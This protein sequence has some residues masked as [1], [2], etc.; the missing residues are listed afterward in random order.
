MTVCSEM[1]SLSWQPYQVIHSLSIDVWIFLSAVF[2][3]WAVQRN[4]R[5]IVSL[6]S[7][8][9][10]FRDLAR[11]KNTDQTKS[12]SRRFWNFSF[13]AMSAVTACWLVYVLWMYVGQAWVFGGACHAV[14]PGCNYLVAVCAV[15][16]ILLYTLKGLIFFVVSHIFNEARCGLF[17][18]R[19]TISYDF[20]F[21]VFAFP[22]LMIFIYSGSWIQAAAFWIVAVLFVIFFVIKTLKAVIVGH[23]YSRFSY[24][25]IFVYFCA[26]EVLL[27]LSLWRIIFPGG[28]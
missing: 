26:L 1:L 12:R 27:T 25:H 28:A 19:M 20:L 15:F 8:L 10:S 6:C 18:W 14:H 22:F 13:L 4:I 3:A 24:L 17:L 9:F 7:H 5:K 23:F 2:Y 11:N 16:T 21:S